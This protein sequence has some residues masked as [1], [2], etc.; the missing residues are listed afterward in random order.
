MPGH[1][2]P[3]GS[4]T[5][6]EMRDWDLADHL[7]GWGDRFPGPAGAEGNVI[8]GGVEVTP[9]QVTAPLPV[10]STER[11][12]TDTTTLQGGCQAFP[13]IRGAPHNI[14]QVLLWKAMMDL[15]D[16]LGRFGL[17]SSEVTQVLHVH[18]ADILPPYDIR[19][20][21]RV[22]FQPVGYEIFESKWN[23]LAARVVARNAALGPQDL[24]CGIR[25]D[26]LLGLGNFADAN[27]QVAFDPLILDQCQKT[28]MAVLIQTIA[29]AASKESFV[30]VVQG[31]EEPFL[32]FAKR[33]TASMEKQVE[34]AE[35][36]KAQSPCEE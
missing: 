11:N 13:V 14:H 9:S 21:A 24:R 6:V 30:T 15:Q 19:H 5:F 16:K 12:P 18:S 36:R 1:G 31:S 34:E 10:D 32:Q 23:Q 28:G 4:Y 7:L 22:L 29:M 35:A 25:T 8:S 3:Q 20:L 2:A 26:V 33:L 17:A 27:K